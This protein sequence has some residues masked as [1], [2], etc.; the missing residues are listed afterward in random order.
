MPRC[1]QCTRFVSVEILGEVTSIDL[2]DTVL[3]VEARLVKTC[4][5][6]GD[7][8]EEWIEQLYYDLED[9]HP[10]CKLEEEQL[11][12]ILEEPTE[13]DIDERG[14]GR[15]RGRKTFYSGKA[16]VVVKCRC[17]WEEGIGVETEAQASHF[18]PL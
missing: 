17:L 13:L 8:L 11:F 10:D 3:E 15:G 7:E 9:Y 1:E 2:E 14:V 5:E 18:D 12:S 6:C 16:E 4:L